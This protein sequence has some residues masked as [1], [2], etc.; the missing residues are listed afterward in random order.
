M[1]AALIGNV[2][3]T[4]SGS[5]LLTQ[6]LKLQ[7]ELRCCLCRAA[8]VDHIAVIADQQ[9]ARKFGSRTPQ[10]LRPRS[11]PGLGILLV[12]YRMPLLLRRGGCIAGKVVESCEGG[13]K[14]LG[15]LFNGGLAQSSVQK[16][17]NLGLCVAALLDLQS[18]K[19]VVRHTP[20][21]LQ[22][23]ALQPALP[24][25]GARCTVH[26]QSQPETRIIHTPSQP[27][28]KQPKQAPLSKDQ[29][30]A[31][32]TPSDPLSHCTAAVHTHPLC[33][34]LSV[35]WPAA[36]PPPAPL[37]GPAPCNHVQSTPCP[38]PAAPRLPHAQLRC[39]QWRCDRLTTF[40][41]FAFVF[42]CLDQEP[43]CLHHLLEQQPNYPPPGLRLA[44]LMYILT[45]ALRS[46]FRALTR[47]L[48]ASSTSW[49]AATRLNS[50]SFC[51]WELS[52]R[53]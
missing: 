33:A 11:N 48:A 26:H 8:A 35:P 41:G 44:Q 39:T 5:F 13:L 45:L 9:R 31:R 49:I 1:C 43:G 32:S 40:H 10:Q 17:G 14:A 46:S 16:A 4:S 36:W 28:V 27:S 53:A 50:S 38:P 42:R 52:S 47:G 22:G 6:R 15:G 34:H 25:H 18:R 2:P 3:L 29:R 7:L 12:H 20:C 51:F 30:T 23:H 21:H 37:G 24:E 19:R